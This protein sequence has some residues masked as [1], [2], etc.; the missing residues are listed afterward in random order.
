MET[1]IRTIAGC[2]TLVVVLALGLVAL[3]VRG[4]LSGGVPRV[5]ARVLWCAGIGAVLALCVL[6]PVAFVGW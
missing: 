1:L 6:G 3:T 2:M 5:G 4:A